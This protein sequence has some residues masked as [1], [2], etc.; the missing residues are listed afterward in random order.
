MAGLNDYRDDVGPYDI[1]GDVHGCAW[2]LER[3]LSELGYRVDWSNENGE[4]VVS[5]A[6]ALGRKLVFL[7]DLVDRGPNSPDCLR[8]AMS[9]VAAGF[10][11]CL[12]GNHEHKFA[13]WLQGRKVVVAHGLQQTIEQVGR[14]T[15]GFRASIPDFLANLRSHLWL[16]E[17]RLVVA[18]AGLR[19]DL[20]GRESA[21]AERFALYG[22]T[23]GETD[24][25]NLPIRRDW[26]AEYRGT[27][28]IVYGHT[29][30]P[31]AKWVNR[32]I[33]IDTGCVFGGKLTALRWPERALVQVNAQ[34]V[35]FRGDSVQGRR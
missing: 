29:A 23:T 10:G 22:D 7:G 5:V 15:P 32:T 3:L 26:A 24:A 35:W 19:E 6:R 4:R 21:A 12:K 16:D 31:E 2:E 13:R 17:G 20:I 11:Y 8:I 34:Q 30:V 28:A 27:A 33:C 18:H 14:N 25:M 9:V 1:V